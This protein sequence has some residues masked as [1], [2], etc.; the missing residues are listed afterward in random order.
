MQHQVAVIT[1]ASG[2]IGSATAQLF[3]AAGAEVVLLDRTAADAENIAAGIGEK[4]WGLG[5]DLT[6]PK[7]VAETIATILAK[8]KRIDSLVNIAGGFRMGPPLHETSESDW[9]FMIKLNAATVFNTCKAVLPSMIANGKGRIANVAARVAENPKANMAP[10]NV[11]KS[12]VVAL[13]KSLAAEQHDSD[14]NINCIMPGTVD[15]PINRTDMPNA[16]HSKWVPTKDLAAVLMF[17][18]SGAA[19]SVNGACIPVYGKS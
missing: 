16:D 8:K 3:A 18:C 2:N 11:S 9:D 1:G 6:D 7:S 10:Y 17:L 14:I 13:T 19:S 5:C 15:T 4:A 12:A